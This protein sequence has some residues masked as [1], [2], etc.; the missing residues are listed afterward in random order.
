[1]RKGGDRHV[2]LIRCLK[3]LQLIGSTR[4]GVTI[5]DMTAELGISRRNIY[6]YITALQMAKIRLH[7]SGGG[8]GDSKRWRLL[9][10]REHLAKIGIL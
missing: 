5:A 4:W 6:R 1:M 9:D 10:Q 7:A 2:C 8:R 3:L